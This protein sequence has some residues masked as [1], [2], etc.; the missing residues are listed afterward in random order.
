MFKKDFI[1]VMVMRGRQRLMNLCV[2]PYPDTLLRRGLKRR[3]ARENADPILEEAMMYSA[4]VGVELMADI[5]WGQR[6]I[7]PVGLG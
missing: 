3:E 1:K 2:D 5:H 6:C 7:Y 4:T